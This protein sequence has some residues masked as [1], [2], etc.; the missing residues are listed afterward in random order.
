MAEVL[1]IPEVEHQV[2][3]EDPPI[4]KLYNGLHADGKYTK[5]FDEFRKIYPGKKRGNTT[6][7]LNFRKKPLKLS[8]TIV[9]LILS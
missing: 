5:S 3:Q 2:T 4:K 9:T 7:F 6:E 1:D 8:S